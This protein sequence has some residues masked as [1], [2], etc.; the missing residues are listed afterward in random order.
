MY[1]IPSE[2]IEARTLMP[3]LQS[4]PQQAQSASGRLTPSPVGSCSATG[5][6]LR[7][8]SQL[9]LAL[10]AATTARHVSFIES[11]RSWPSPEMVL[12]LARVLDVPIRERNQLLLAAGYAPMYRESGLAGEESAKVLA[13]LERMLTLHEPYPAVVMD[14]HWNVTRTNNAAGDFFGWLLEGRGDPGEPPNVIRLMFDPAGLRPFVVNWEAAAEALIQRI[15]REAIGGVPDPTTA[16]LLKEALAYPDVPAQWRSPDFR[17]RRCR[18]C[19]SNS[20]RPG[21]R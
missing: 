16:A 8:L 9:A 1:S 19:L 4:C 20:K 11:G 12:R 17:P 10:E 14:R 15:H 7:R 21:W 3:R 5:G 6:E 18:S 2:G 13:A